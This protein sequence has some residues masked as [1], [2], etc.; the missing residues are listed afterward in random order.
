MKYSWNIF[1]RRESDICKLSHRSD[2]NEIWFNSKTFLG[3]EK[4]DKYIKKKKKKKKKIK[5]KKKKRRKDKPLHETTRC[6]F[7]E[8]L[9][10]L[11]R[12]GK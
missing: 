3:K 12:Y 8:Q 11:K 1:A 7:I 2:D 10:C 4:E 9:R 5:K 6:Y